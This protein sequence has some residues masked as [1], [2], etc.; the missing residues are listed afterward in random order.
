MK[1]LSLTQA[2]ILFDF[3]NQNTTD[4]ENLTHIIKKQRGSKGEQFVYRYPYV[5]LYITFP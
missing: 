5:K 1:V 3:K 2:L 4:T